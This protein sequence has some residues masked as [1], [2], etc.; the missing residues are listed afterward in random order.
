MAS[1]IGIL[2]S[3]SGTNAQALLDASA[4]N[5]LSGG[6]VVVL[7]SDR[8]SAGALVRAE[9]SGVEAS[10]CDPA[11]HGTREEYGQALVAELQARSV[12]LVCLAGFM[13]I[14]PAQFIDAFGGRVLN[15]HPALLPA[16]PGANAV[17]EALKRGVRV[18]GA[19]VHYATEEVDAGP[20]VL[21]ECV[22]VMPGDDLTSLHERIKRVE[23]RIYPEAV[24][25]IV[26]GHARVEGQIVLISGDREARPL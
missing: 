12:D 1:R 15:V 16:F 24:R 20:I 11:P 5:D 21:Q 4:R 2:A 7:I 25:L 22:P 10:F 18:T 19:T 17:D 14:L 6:S 26:G 9:R 3:G 13:R 23:H 8:P